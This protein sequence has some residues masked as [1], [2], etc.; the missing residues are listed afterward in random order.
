VDCSCYAMDVVTIHH[1]R[2]AHRL[3]C[4][5]LHKRVLCT[6]CLLLQHTDSSGSRTSVSALLLDS[7]VKR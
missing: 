5:F 7:H 4:I 2:C 6:T 3:G 1:H